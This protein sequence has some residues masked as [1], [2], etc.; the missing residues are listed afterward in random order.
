MTQLSDLL[1]MGPLHFRESV[2]PM[3]LRDVLFVPGMKKNLILISMIKDMGLGVS[4]LDGN[5][6]VFPKTVGPFASYTIGA[7]CGK[8]YK[9]FFQPQHALT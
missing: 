5:V 8:L 1:G 3:I 6:C 7:R 2:S 9:L 4:F